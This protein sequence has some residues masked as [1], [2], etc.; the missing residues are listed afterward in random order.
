MA[1]YNGSING[2]DYNELMVC[3]VPQYET[4]DVNIQS[5]I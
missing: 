5:S 2:I 1:R 4:V 3:T